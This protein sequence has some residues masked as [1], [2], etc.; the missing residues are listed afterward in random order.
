MSKKQ[1]RPIDKYDEAMEN[2]EVNQSETNREFLQDNPIIQNDYD[3][4]MDNLY[5]IDNKGL[6]DI[7]NIYDTADD[8]T[9]KILRNRQN[10]ENLDAILTSPYIADNTPTY[11]APKGTPGY[12][13]LFEQ[14]S[15]PRNTWNQ[16]W[17]SADRIH[18]DAIKYN[19]LTD[20]L[21]LKDILK[22]KSELQKQENLIKGFEKDQQDA[23]RLSE[24]EKQAA[25]LQSEIKKNKLEL[26]ETEKG[27]AERPVDAMFSAEGRRLMDEESSDFTD[28]WM[29]GE[30][31]EDIGGAMSDFKML[32]MALA[33]G[34]GSNKLAK[35]AKRLPGA[36]G[37]VIPPVVTL[38]G[39][40][41]GGGFAYK[42]RQHESD[43]EAYGAYEQRVKDLEARHLLTTGQPPTAKQKESI[44]GEAIKGMKSMHQQNMNLLAGDFAQVS[45]MFVPWGKVMSPFVA[46]GS[47]IPGV[48]AAG[49]KLSTGM[50]KLPKWAWNPRNAN[51]LRTMGRAVP[52]MGAN[53]FWEGFEEGY[54]YTLADDYKQG[55]YDEYDPGFFENLPPSFDATVGSV[56][57]VYNT[58]VGN[59]VR[60][61]FGFTEHRDNNRTDSKEFRNAVRAGGLLGLFMGGGISL[62]QNALDF[63]ENKTVKAKYQEEYNLIN[64][65]LDKYYDSQQRSDRA[66]ILYNVFEKDGGKRLTRALRSHEEYT[67]QEGLTDK[68]D[69]VEYGK[70]NKEVADLK[71]YYDLLQGDK[72]KNL[73]KEDKV[74]ALKAFSHMRHVSET[75]ISEAAIAEKE[76][77]RIAKKARKSFPS[78]EQFNLWQL[79]MN[80]MS[81]KA[82]GASH[83]KVKP[84]KEKYGSAAYTKFVNSSF[85]K[86]NNKLLKEAEAELKAKM[87][88][89][90]VKTIP[91]ISEN[92]TYTD[93]L[94]RKNGGLMGAAIIAPQLMDM[95]DANKAFKI[96][97]NPF[98]MDMKAWK[99]ATDAYNKR[100]TKEINDYLNSTKAKD[101][102]INEGDIVWARSG[103]LKGKYVRKFGINGIENKDGFHPLD[104]EDFA[105]MERRILDK[106]KV[107]DIVSNSNKQRTSTKVEKN[108]DS[109]DTQPVVDA[110]NTQDDTKKQ[111][112]E[113]KLVLKQRSDQDLSTPV[114]FSAQNEDFSYK[115]HPNIQAGKEDDAVNK[116]VN[117]RSRED[118]KNLIVQ[119]IDINTEGA[120][121]NINELISR[122][123]PIDEN[124][125]LRT[126]NA[127]S[128]FGRNVKV[129][130]KLID[131][132]TNQSVETY[133]YNI[134]STSEI[135]ESDNI[136]TT[137]KNILNARILNNGPLYGSVSYV[138][139]G[140][141]NNIPGQQGKISK[142]FGNNKPHLAINDGKGITD[143]IN[144]Y[145]TVTEDGVGRGRLYAIFT[146]PVDNTTIPVKLN[147]RNLTKEETNELF[148]IVEKFLNSTTQDPFTFT[149]LYKDTGLT[150]SQYMNLLTFVNDN[151][152]LADDQFDLNA[153]SATTFGFNPS[154]S[155]R[156]AHFQFGN[157]TINKNMLDQE[158]SKARTAF[159]NHVSKFKKRH[160]HA[161]GINSS[162]FD[163]PFIAS[164]GVTEFTFLGK[165][166]KKG[167]NDNYNSDFVEADRVLTTDLEVL[168]NGR[169][170]K[171]RRLVIDIY[172]F[173]GK[174]SVLKNEDKINELPED[175]K[176][177]DTTPVNDEEFNP[178]MFDQPMEI[179]LEPSP[180]ELLNPK[181][182]RAYLDKV[183]GTAVPVRVKDKLVKLGSNGMEVYAAFTKGV[184]ELS[185]MAPKGAEYHEAYHAVET[186]YLTSSEIAALNA[187]T[188]LKHGKPT[189]ATIS[190]IQKKYPTWELTKN[191][192]ESIALSEIRAEEYRMYETAIQDDRITF[193]NLGAK[194][195]RW[196]NELIDYLVPMFSTTTA[197]K[198]YSRIS[199]G[200]Y[201][202]N[203]N[204]ILSLS[205]NNLSQ[206]IEETALEE[207]GFSIS[208]RNAIATSL[209]YALVTNKGLKNIK[210]LTDIKITDNILKGYLN[211][212]QKIRKEAGNQSVANN[213]EIIK[214][215]IKYF[216]DAETNK[217]LVPD[218][219]SQY[220]IKLETD[221]DTK[222][223]KDV[224]QAMSS[225]F[226][227]SGKDNASTNTKILLS[228]LAK[229]NKRGEEIVDAR[230]GLTEI[231]RFSTVWNTIE[232]SLA[233]ITS[234]AEYN[235]QNELV[236][237]NAY[238]LMMKSL[239]RL[240]ELVPTFTGLSSKIK[241]L[242][243]NDQ[244]RFFNAFSKASMNFVTGITDKWS[245][246]LQEE[247]GELMNIEQSNTRFIDPAVQGRKFAIRK[248]WLEGLKNKKFFILKEEEENLDVN[249]P[250][251]ETILK[252]WDIM[253]KGY[254]SELKR[255]NRDMDLKVSEEY[256]S[257]LISNLKVS[258][259]SLSTMGLDVLLKAEATEA[260]SLKTLF[261]GKERNFG[262]QDVYVR[263]TK[264]KKTGRNPYDFS[265]IKVRSENVNAPMDLNFSENNPFSWA[266]SA[267]NMLAEAEALVNNSMGQ[268]NI[269][270]PKGKS[271]WLYS[272]N[273]YLSKFSNKL[274]A[275]TYEGE[276]LLNDRWSK[277]SS[278][279]K[280]ILA[281]NAI[282]VRTF[283]NLKL[284][285]SK[286]EGTSN[287]ELT[288][289]QEHAFRINSTLDGIARQKGLLSP[290]TMADKSI[291]NLIEGMSVYDVFE[292]SDTGFE[293][294]PDG[295]IRL[296]D[297]ISRK[298][299]LYAASE[300]SRVQAVTEELFGK[301]KLNDTE[302]TNYYHYNG[303]NEDNTRNRD[304]ANGLK[305]ILFPSLTSKFLKEAGIMSEDG[306]FLDNWNSDLVLD[307]LTKFV[308]PILMN[309]IQDEISFALENGVII[310]TKPTE[311]TIIYKNNSISTKIL[312]AHKEKYGQK[313]G[314]FKEHYGIGLAI[315]NYSINNLI[316]N[317]ETTKLYSQD[318]AFYKN[319]D[320]LSKRFPELIA[321]GQ[322]LKIIK[323]HETYTAAIIEDQILP[324]AKYYDNYLK[325][326][327]EKKGLSRD[328]AKKILKPYLN[329]NVTD[330][331]AYITLPRWRSLMRMLGKW[332][333]K[334]DATYFRVLNGEIVDDT[335]FDMILAQPLKGMH[336]ETRK[337][338]TADNGKTTLHIPTYLKYSQAVLIPSVVKG[339]E[340]SKLLEAMN[341]QH[342]DEVV[343]ESGIKVGALSPSNIMQNQ[344]TGELSNNIVLNPFILK[345]EFWKLQQDLKPHLESESLEGSQVKKNIIGNIDLEAMYKVPTRIANG[346]QQYKEISGYELVKELHAIDRSLSDLEKD[347]MVNEW[348]VSTE[349]VDM[350]TG[351]VKYHIEDYTKLHSILYNA[352][353]AKKNTPKKL[354]E[355]LALNESGTGF[356]IDISSH[357]FMRDIESMLGAMITDRLV[358]L[359]MPGGSFIQQSNFGM[360]RMKK[361]SDLPQK[362]KIELNKQINERGL[363]A[364]YNSKDGTVR[365]QIFL[366]SWFK[367]KHV[368]GHEQMSNK[369]IA[370][371]I[372]DKRL[373]TAVGYRI[374]NQ[375]MSSIDSFD[376]VGFL[377]KSVGDTVIV[378]DEFTAK[379]GADFDIDKLYIM[380]P[381]YA[382]SKKGLYYVNY[383][384]TKT[385]EENRQTRGN[386]VELFKKSLRNRKLE[387]YQ[388]ILTSNNTFDQLINPLDSMATKEDAALVRYLKV[389]STLLPS[390]IEE[391][392]AARE[393]EDFYSTVSSVLASRNDLEFFS[394]VYQMRTKETFLGGK[395]GVGQEA[396]HLVDH[397]ISQWAL[398]NV[399]SSLFLKGKDI[400][401][402]RLTPQTMVTDLSSI[403]DTAG[404]L[405]SNTMSARLDA[406]VD[407]AKDPY[408]FYLN[409]NK[410]TANTVALLDRAGVDPRWTNRFMGLR[411]LSD[412]VKTQ[413]F[414]NSPG[415]PGVNIN[416]KRV[417]KAEQVLRNRLLTKYSALTGTPI[418]DIKIVNL[419]KEDSRIRM[420]SRRN[421]IP[422]E[423][424]V[425]LNAK[426][427]I[428]ISDII[429]TERLE[430]LLDSSQTPTANRTYDE[431]LLL[432]LFLN[433]KGTASELNKA[434]TASK[435]D[436]QGAAGGVVG[437]IIGQNNIEAVLETDVIGGFS[438][439]FDGTM[440]GKY[441]ENGP[442]MMLS[443]FGNT[444][445]AGNANFKGIMKDLSELVG[446]EKVLQNEDLYRKVYAGFISYLFSKTPFYKGI[447]VTDILY[448]KN[449]VVNRLWRYKNEDN[450]PIKDNPFVQYLSP[451]FSN[452]KRGH[453]YIITSASEK[454]EGVDK[455]SLTEGWNALLSSEDAAVRKFAEDLYKFS[456]LSSGFSNTLFSFHELA[457]LQYELDNGVYDQFGQQVLDIKTHG[458]IIFDETELKKFLK[459][460]TSNTELV[461]E[462]FA[463]SPKVIKIPGS[464]I[465]YVYNIVLPSN[466]ARKFITREPKE[467]FKHFVPFIEVNVKGKQ[468]VLMEHIGYNEKGDAIYQ[469]TERT[470][471]YKKGRK[472]FENAENRTEL[473]ENQIVN[474]FND[475]VINNWL[476]V[477]RQ[478]NKLVALASIAAK[479][480]KGGKFIPLDAAQLDYD[481]QSEFSNTLNNEEDFTSTISEEQDLHTILTPNYKLEESFP[482]V[483][484][485]SKGPR[486]VGIFKTIAEAINE[487]IEPEVAIKAALKYNLELQEYIAGISEESV[488]YDKEVGNY[489]GY[490]AAWN[491]FIGLAARGE[492]Q[493]IFFEQ[494]KINQMDYFLDS[495]PLTVLLQQFER[496]LPVKSAYSPIINM[497]QELTRDTHTEIVYTSADVIK[498]SR[499]ESSVAFY[500]LNANRVF[501]PLKIN[502]IKGY[503]K[504]E[505]EAM[506]LLHETI[507]NMTAQSLHKPWNSKTTTE[508]MF[509]VRVQKLLDL[510]IEKTKLKDMP[511]QLQT[512]V[513]KYIK[514]N[515]N[516]LSG[517]KKY[518]NYGAYA[519]E[520]N[521]V[522]DEFLA[523]GLTFKKVMK[524]L[525]NIQI[526]EEGPLFEGTM[527]SNLI[528]SIIDLFTSLMDKVIGTNAKELLEITFTDFIKNGVSL[529]KSIEDIYKEIGNFALPSNENLK[530][531][532]R[533]SK[534]VKTRAKKKC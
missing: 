277:S 116:F 35:Y 171:D 357:P 510:Y 400:G 242:E 92:K 445:L 170:Q 371:Y 230:T 202:K 485:T 114:S 106:D 274:N 146:D 420:Y 208:D 500:D 423:D 148:E 167:V 10:D 76:A 314:K 333:K 477:L 234:Y 83:K 303:N 34:Y 145:F 213:L 391:I 241:N 297:N 519:E 329:I 416:G 454:K 99:K 136:V 91:E 57:G 78:D 446:N 335:N 152:D 382:E 438:E 473:K 55:K 344:E 409:N 38:G 291:W 1:Y 387:L 337:G 350:L 70:V 142:L 433:L 126:A 475:K 428:R 163:I 102:N 318:P 253:K 186:S 123:E 73:T 115:H 462:Y 290:P 24:I 384:G 503:S 310:R 119:I 64:D 27:I 465:S 68:S 365:A 381:S 31:G 232:K 435:A 50:N 165:V 444:F 128:Q 278:W 390:Q 252:S 153:A 374:P 100:K 273:N 270:G 455:D 340:L 530:F 175:L 265:S 195:K 63:A 323:G 84:G 272:L 14:Q 164:T 81:L 53:G 217:G 507:H 521:N 362:V 188:R 431:L 82:I 499:A 298:I 442:N 378:Y 450:S 2:M 271:Y 267:I 197:A 129:K 464:K 107:K 45:M 496:Q 470:G 237:Y 408:I 11:I 461:P 139:F 352:F 529:D 96:K 509:Q 315:A 377:P 466:S 517:E 248:E 29:S 228:F 184:I 425:A 56:P 6:K 131:P 480:N 154:T 238:D 138:D 279:L 133:L 514:I 527:L 285:N 52:I 401:L 302:L 177:V 418:A 426:S 75:N 117:S 411:V 226:E 332:D 87:K 354:L 118:L 508:K 105:S 330:A 498:K 166:Y 525:E 353:K 205:I 18:G 511:E 532:N 39:M 311:D 368:P 451:E 199:R 440:L 478:N 430:S 23:K 531:Y 459:T 190:E 327:I 469:L 108:K 79:A 528:K 40:L 439:R 162:I 97:K 316:S 174:P 324:K 212:I 209:I 520:M 71:S 295:T 385:I 336:F 463:K 512:A 331:Q 49:S 185:K 109:Q 284:S 414:I 534:E 487:G 399:E 457:P 370:K 33:T 200:H 72:Y 147:N 412:Y 256:K 275:S 47:K 257:E 413:D 386:R 404:G 424:A 397:A 449:N 258:G 5:K 235:S 360:Q 62:A 65:N 376:I 432:N 306:L 372:K 93:A 214:D 380:L 216:F 497:M 460:Q 86:A 207:A 120:P 15:D 198:I 447:D 42:M 225:H 369:E 130:I 260:E 436:T 313:G 405:I 308:K 218:I 358:K 48:A 206:S 17:N 155:T 28:Y 366:P 355:S 294:K 222:G 269:L 144:P 383:D 44:Q 89:L 19:I 69:M 141:F 288:P 173:T 193:K 264:S 491:K 293:L 88:E 437:A 287:T 343:F 407:I 204:K 375:A 395:F 441:Q 283:N 151:T 359:K 94:V 392:E 122:K 127:K 183:L 393:T 259:I 505:T 321:P 429:T 37:K 90:G 379:T 481:S 280:S 296:G 356:A 172:E 348:G 169:I 493:Q 176:G 367:E 58:L 334:Y 101:Q 325:F 472:I 239:E 30:M 13:N 322:D 229:R 67:Q 339:T 21:E 243:E 46:A 221:E 506:V 516:L 363:G 262:L 483:I 443:L 476:G 417:F 249:T 26:Q 201:R 8:E 458:N 518:F 388:S 282:K 346:E 406:Y 74:D 189:D 307:K 263:T 135:E 12:A 453:D 479:L 95:Q 522:F 140:K 245:Y 98:Y 312:K 305:F 523:Y 361:F 182:A 515:E 3:D 181:E 61:L 59:P 244:I 43:A 434:V 132:K 320:D 421:N 266:N 203:S 16:I 124:V 495:R 467:G 77:S 121:S 504:T 215:N 471:T 36:W 224:S 402:G 292:N 448:S 246:Q 125:D 103:N 168:S 104:A 161:A 255:M 192:A 211:Y 178:D 233:D 227:Y 247:G 286:D 502:T 317:I 486:I 180:T 54:Q 187:E 349:T 328:E 389:K 210:N 150:V 191:T 111:L 66:D 341:T 299:A 474:V 113:D 301:N 492:G 526:Q 501:M 373:L 60:G 80:V 158:R 51:R 319:L 9:I 452:T 219:L 137:F 4:R 533:L 85:I 304:S 276:Q 112:K 415:S 25:E 410:T 484:Q 254:M 268:S 20:E 345:N 110:S 160:A 251:L 427:P 494:Q 488:S 490:A 143:G 347:A 194:L 41:A 309:R 398:E 326:L 351:Q 32:S 422:L 482:V 396:R 403:T 220:K 281:G 419:L 338:K 7:K 300:I 513:E 196:F 364:V 236:V 159:M 149:S 394:P 156:S 134:V 22:E 456:I 289:S 524:Q 223:N 157:L 261:L 489:I 250:V 179:I 231:E 468:V 240:S 342:V